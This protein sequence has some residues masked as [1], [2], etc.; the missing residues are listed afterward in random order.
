MIQW[1][2][3]RLLA[4]P[5]WTRFS[6]NNET[7]IQWAPTPTQ[8]LLNTILAKQRDDDSVGLHKGGF[9]KWFYSWTRL[10]LNGDTKIQWAYKWLKLRP[11]CQRW[12]LGQRRGWV[13][14]H[15]IIRISC[16]TF[17]LLLWLLCLWLRSCWMSLP[18]LF[19]NDIPLTV[20]QGVSAPDLLVMDLNLPS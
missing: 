20:V 2:C 3:T 10:P 14:V 18:V 17:H 13:G 5:R 6:L 11:G 15:I 9:N 4:S 8:L 1:A 12:R 19:R 16:E 7:M